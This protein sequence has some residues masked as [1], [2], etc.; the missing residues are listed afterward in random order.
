LASLI[1]P[2][3]PDPERRISALQEIASQGIPT[4][5]RVDPIIPTIN[6]NEA[7]FEELVSTLAAIGVKQVTISTLKPVRGFFNKLMNV[8]PELH[9]KLWKEYSNGSWI[10]GYKYLNEAKRWKILE[11]LRPIVLKHGL[12]FASCRE[13]FS[14]LNTALCDGTEICRG[15]RK[16]SI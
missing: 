13:G 6:D 11:K 14:D 15:S 12:T 4:V 1:E 8:D 10:L 5:A 3:A 2:N 9:K 7:D 16:S